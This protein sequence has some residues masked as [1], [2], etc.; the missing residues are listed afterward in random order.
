MLVGRYVR[1]FR[2]LPRLRRPRTFQEHVLAKLLFDRDPKLTL[3]ADK[4][5]V[6]GYVAR[7]LGG[8]QNLTTLYAAVD[9]ADAI[10]GLSL[11][12]RFVMK[13]NHLTGRVRIVK[14]LAS[15]DRGELE[16]LA[17]QWLRDN[18]GLQ[19]GEWAYRDIRPRILFEEL[20]EWEGRPPNDYRFWCFGGEPRMVVV[21]RDFLGSDPTGTSYD[22][23]FRLLPMR[24]V[25]GRSRHVSLQEKPPPNY[26]EMVQIA[27]KLSAGTDFLRVDLYNL[28]GSIVFGELTNYPASGLRKFD[29]PSWDVTLGGYW[30]RQ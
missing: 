20:L 8:E 18:L 30:S 14:D 1:H 12:N 28:G 22:I 6:R 9:R 13:P 17:A 25:G 15:I 19:N 23:H 21:N 26:P 3:F 5:A 10:G 27:R 29:P 4:Y 16:A 24:Q 2:K 7:I 11:P